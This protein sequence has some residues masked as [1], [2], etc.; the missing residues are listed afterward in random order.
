VPHARSLDRFLAP[1]SIAV[2][3][4]SP[5]RTKIRGQ[6]L[7]MLRENRYPGRL[8]PVNPSYRE[9]EGLA[10]YPSLAAIGAPVDLAVIAIPA[11]AVLAALEECA[12]AGVG[13][14]VI[15]SSGFAEQGGAQATLQDRIAELA[16]RTGLRIAGP[17]AE[18]FYN[19]PARVAATFSPTVEVKPDPPPIAS[20]RRIGIV[21][22]SG[23][24][25]FALYNRGHALG[26]SFSVVVSTG[27][28]ADLTASDFFAHL[29]GDD[30]TAL[31]MLFIEGVRDPERF[32]AA[33]RLAAER[34]K[35]VIAA[36]MGRT[37]AGARAARS[38]TASMAGWDT[39]YEAVFR[40]YG[41]IA[42]DDPDEAVAMAAAFATAP[43]PKGDRV[44]VVTTSGGAG[45]WAADALAAAG[46]AV[47]ELPPAL[48]Q[49]IGAFIPAYGSARNP[50]D[51]TAQAVRTGGLQRAIE[52]LSAAP[53]ID[54]IVVVL[55]LASETRITIDVAALRGIVAAQA[56]PVQFYSYSLPSP[57]GRK[58]L[59]EAGLT[60]HTGLAPLAAAMRAL[61]RRG[62]FALLPPTPANA[63]TPL[64][65]A[66]RRGLAEH[67]AKAILAAA[68]LAMPEGR[69]VTCREELAPAA[70][71]LG[72][73]LAL[74]IQSPDLPHKTEVEGVRLGIADDTA[75]AAAFDSVIAAARRHR[76]AAHLD[77][78]LLERM[79]RPGVEMIVG[80]I[81][82]A[83]FGPLVMVGA[84]GVMT[85]LLRDAVYRLA[86]VDPAEARAMLSELRAAPLLEGFRGAPAADIEALAQ[87]IA[88]V[89]AFAA[90]HRDRLQ[91]ID[92]NPV[93]VHRRGEG[94]TV[95]DALIL[96]AQ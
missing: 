41:I 34:G 15:I 72:F 56:K 58:V 91:E 77:G 67:D 11:E 78:V 43:L 46:L 88:Q 8:C 55:S 29:A 82:D 26:L 69:L 85:E 45:A 80:T 61:A 13:Y 36:K 1:H 86:P 27:N 71:A 6:L 52:L 59:A 66:A 54:A 95:A 47:P 48:Q 7:H 32:L 31:I 92:L 25:G 83:V 12:A 51:I 35:P 87:L 68:G 73:P 22:Q 18:G 75:L 84:G 90:A 39:A 50:V 74:K 38:H 62:V 4:A 37:G 21:A 5:E 17:N 16:Q 57:L 53:E 63:V 94:C 10:C 70:A 9:I 30:E 64:P 93:I 42:A 3:G 23:G 65:T 24:M 20:R 19:A 89:S 79:A 40:R 33:A 76:P 28:E 2:I 96:P 44:A 14:A 49:A 81:R 60:L